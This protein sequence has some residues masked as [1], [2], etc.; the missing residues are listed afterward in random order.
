[1][2]SQIKGLLLALLGAGGALYLQ[3]PL[4]WLVGPV[5]ASLVAGTMQIDMPCHPYWRKIGQLIIGMLLGLQF[6]PLLVETIASYAVWI[7][8]AVLWSLLLGLGLALAQYHFN[9]VDWSTAW[10]SSAIG[11]ASEM[12]TLA[13]H[14]SA[15]VDRVAAS[16]S[17]RLVL[18]VV[19][20]PIL[21]T[22]MFP[23]LVLVPEVVVPESNLWRT[24]VV[25]LLAVVLAQ[26]AQRL[27]FLNAWLLVPLVCTAALTFFQVTDIYLPKGWIAFGQ[28]C[29][30]W[31][32][33]SQFPFQFLTRNRKFLLLTLLFHTV[34]L[35]LSLLF[36]WAIAHVSQLDHKLLLLGLS[37]GGIAEMSLLA[38]TLGLTVPV[39]VAFQLSRLIF[40]ISSTSFFYQ[41]TRPYFGQH[42]PLKTLDPH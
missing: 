21:M 23:T 28:L 17:L 25:V 24:G 12:V 5:V 3:L 40:V 29:I 41:R 7:G 32:L 34:A 38:Q 36:A 20:M 11:S 26:L 19:A 30:G 1:M 42:R 8:L 39:I 9:R 14:H 6:S 18:V 31:S 16:H 15:Q 22:M 27:K 2:F 33:G 13:E 10:F 35:A 4:P 37:P